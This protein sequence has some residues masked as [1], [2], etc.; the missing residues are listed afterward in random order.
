[1][2][3]GR[4]ERL[5]Y[6]PKSSVSRPP[7]CCLFTPR[8]LI[9]PCQEGVPASQRGGKFGSEGMDEGVCYAKDSWY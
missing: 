3:G 1:M 9:G 6:H 2:L 5:G 4:K 7:G 8:Q